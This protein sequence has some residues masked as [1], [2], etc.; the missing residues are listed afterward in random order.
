MTGT[1]PSGAHGFFT[2]AVRVS[3]RGDGN[4]HA[5]QPAPRR[6]R[7]RPGR[8]RL[9][10]LHHRAAGRRL[11]HLRGH[12]P[13]RDGDPGG[14]RRR[15]SP[16]SHAGSLWQNQ[17]PVSL[18]AGQLTPVTL[19][20]TSLTDHA[21]RSAGRAPASAGSSSRASTCTPARWSPGWAIPT[22]GSS[23]PPRSRPALSL[24]AAEL[25]YLATSLR[26]AATGSWLNDLTAHGRP[27]RG[28][29]RRPV[30]R[31]RGPARLLPDQAG[32]V[33]RRR[34]LLTVLQDPACPAARPAVRAAEPHRLGA[35]LR[36]PR[37]SPSSSAART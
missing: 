13:G 32:P 12:R 28:H 36:R 24:T 22:P 33:P 3:H 37:C 7:R 2:L 11:R 23:R 20:A 1:D 35:G 27:G 16:A 6:R 8:R 18:V 30:R 31:A 26:P 5:G 14:R 21:R 25:A 17:G 10:R 19:T 9:E 4:L 15:R 29:G 34:R